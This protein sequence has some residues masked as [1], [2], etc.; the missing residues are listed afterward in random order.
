MLNSLTAAQRDWVPATPSIHGLGLGLPGYLI[1]FAP[2]AFAPQRQLWSSA[3][4][5]PQVFLPISTHFTATPGIPRTSPI[6][7]HGSFAC[8]LQLNPEVL[9][10]TYPHPY[11]PLT[12]HN[13]QQPLPPPDYPR[14]LPRVNRGFFHRY[15]HNRPGRKEFTSQGTSSSTRRCCVRVS[16]IAQNS[17]LLPPVGVWTVFQFQCGRA[18]SQAGYRS[19][20]WWAITPPTSII[21]RGLLFQRIAAFLL[22][23][24]AVLSPVS[25]RYSP[26]KGR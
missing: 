26:L 24:Y 9:P 2:L 14:L 18:P 16:P 17:P 20:P 25:R 10:G 3:P 22:R 13:S 4:L 7:Q 6:L 12:A 23:D 5:S 1:L 19:S 8:R 11:P 21:S 15:R